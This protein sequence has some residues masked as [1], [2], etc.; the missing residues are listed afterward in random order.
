MKIEK[1]ELLRYLG[2]R[3]QQYD[4]NIERNIDRAIDICLEKITP[5]NVIKKFSLVK[6]PLSLKDADMILQGND[7][8]KHLEDCNEAY[9]LGATVGFEIERTVDKLMKDNPLLGVMVDSASIC[10]IES[11]CDDLCEHIQSLNT[12]RLTWRFSCGYGDFPLAQQKDFVRLLEMQKRI[13]V[14]INEDSFMMSPQKSVTAI[15]GVKESAKDDAQYKRCV[16]KCG[17]C[18]NVKCEYRRN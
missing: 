4:D 5:R 3:G 8:A 12:K 11:Y 9:I 18:N 16:G 1:S 2:Y 13:G 7:I 6:E 14:F 17:N 15:I 10:A